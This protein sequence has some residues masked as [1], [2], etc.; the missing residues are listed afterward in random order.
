[1]NRDVRAR[2]VPRG[3]SSVIAVVMMVAIAVI[4]AS[5]ASAFVLGYTDLIRDPAPQASFTF[6]WE[7][8]TRTLTIEHAAGDAFT[9]KNTERLEVVIT[10]EDETGQ[11]D[12]LE[13]RGDWASRAGGGFDITADDQFVI[14][15]EAG[16]G[17]L[18]VE[19][20]GTDVSDASQTHEPEIGDEVRVVWY[21][22]DGRSFDVARYTIPA[23]E[24]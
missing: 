23:G 2:S 15:G 13:A 3:V 12:Y 7:E 8:S 21:G 1:M 9:A 11:N 20:V 10:D 18:D 14:T 6:D 19:L 4:V 17:D 5:V 24:D 16:G 22:P